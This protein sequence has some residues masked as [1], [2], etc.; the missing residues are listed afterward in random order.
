MKMENKKLE[1]RLEKLEKQQKKNEMLRE[2]ISD[3]LKIWIKSME[4]AAH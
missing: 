2:A 3:V 1:N 4:R